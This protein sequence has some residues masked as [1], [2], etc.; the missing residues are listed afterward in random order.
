ME[1]KNSTILLKLG[2][3]YASAHSRTKKIITKNSFKTCRKFLFYHFFQGIF[4]RFLRISWNMCRAEFDQNQIC[5]NRYLLI[6]FCIRFRIYEQNIFLPEKNIVKKFGKKIVK[7]FVMKNFEYI[8]TTS[9]EI[10]I[11]KCFFFTGSLTLRIILGQELNLAT[12]GE[13]RGFC[14]SFPRK[15]LEE[16]FLL[17]S[18]L[19]EYIF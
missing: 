3:P 4:F 8:S 18:I 1:K 14:K 19:I 6:F 11:G 10:K 9:Q 12:F 2:S 5:W 15:S 17:I 13:R 7:H 16:I